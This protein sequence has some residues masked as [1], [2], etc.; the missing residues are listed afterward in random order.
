MF[1]RF[2]QIFVGKIRSGL[3]TM[4]ASTEKN[5]KEKRDLVLKHQGKI[6]SL[7]TECS[8]V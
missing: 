4:V 1:F 8:E 5:E 3:E 2:I 7:D 6:A